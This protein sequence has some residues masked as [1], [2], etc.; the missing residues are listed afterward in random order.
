MKKK[1]GSGEPV[2]NTILDAAG[3][4]GTGKWTGITAFNLG[5]PLTLIAESVFAR[6][7]S[8]LKDER[9]KAA[10]VYI[11][12][13]QKFKGDKKKF[14]NDIRDALY[15]SKIVSYAQGFNLMKAA[16]KKY[17][18]DLNFGNIALIWRGGCIIRSVFLKKIKEAFDND[19]DIENILLDP[20]FVKEIKNAVKGWRRAVITAAQNGIPVPTMTS[21][22]SYFDGFRC[23]RLPANLLQAQRDFFGAHTYE[24]TDRPRGEYF[25][26][27]WTEESGATSSSSYSI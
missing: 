19:P 15:A 3:Q 11:E 27:A 24:R 25:H 9:T 6:C 12:K 22:L 10:A 8:G 13:P 7:L 23:S 1:D 4:K 16:D 14:I 18:W 2:I 20:Y 21:A 17:G 5:V 26:T